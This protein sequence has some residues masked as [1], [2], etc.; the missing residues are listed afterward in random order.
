MDSPFA[1]ILGANKVFTG[2]TTSTNQALTGV[3]TG[4]AFTMELQNDGYATIYF[5]WGIGTQTATAA[6][7]PVLPGQ[8]KIV[9]CA[10]GTNNVAAFATALTSGHATPG[11]GR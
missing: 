8:S 10:P 5:H 1:P 4:I 11:N 2:V 3:P 7:Y 9:Q 6:S